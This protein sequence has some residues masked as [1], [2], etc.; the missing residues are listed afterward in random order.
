MCIWFRGI[1]R[2]YFEYYPHY[3]SIDTNNSINAL[4]WQE[5]VTIAMCHKEKGHINV[6]VKVI[7]IKNHNRLQ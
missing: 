4:E 1:T 7:L 3:L 5:I 2:P 6:I